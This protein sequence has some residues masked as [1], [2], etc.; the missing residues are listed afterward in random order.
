VNEVNVHCKL[1]TINNHY[2]GRSCAS[3]SYTVFY[4]HNYKQQVI[5]H[6]ENEK[7]LIDPSDI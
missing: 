7:V 3:Q 4:N 2:V 6:I 5:S 1:G